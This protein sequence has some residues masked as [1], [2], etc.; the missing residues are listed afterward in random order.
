MRARPDGSGLRIFVGVWY[1][2]LGA[3]IT[4]LPPGPLSPPDP[5]VWLRGL[6][7]VA[8]GLAVFWL[9]PIDKRWLSLLGHLI[10]AG[11]QG[12]FAA[13]MINQGGALSPGLT[14]LV[15]AI[16]TGALPLYTLRS[17]GPI[18]GLPSYPLG[19]VAAAMCAVQGVATVTGSD[20][21]ALI[22]MAAGL[23]PQI[24]G[25][26][27]TLIG[28]LA[29][30]VCWTGFGGRRLVALT[31]FP[32]ALF[33]LGIAISA[34]LF[35]SSAYW[36]LNASGYV[37]AAALFLAPWAAAVTIDWRSAFA[38]TAVTVTSTAI[39]PLMLVMT[40]VLY[41]PGWADS[42]SLSDRQLLFGLIVLLIV[43]SVFGAL[44]AAR[45]LTGPLF[46][47]AQLL[48]KS[49]VEVLAHKADSPI[50]E[51]EILRRA[52]LDLYDKLLAQNAQ[53][54]RANSSK[55][56]F[57]GLVSHELKT[58]ITTIL[59]A[60][61]L[62]R[63]RMGAGEEGLV[64]DLEAETDR[65][66][67]IVDNLLA[68]ARM[69][70]GANSMTEPLMLSHLAKQE[71][72]RAGRRDT[73]REYRFRTEGEAVVDGVDE[74]IVM[75]L[76]N[77][78]TNA[79]KYSP[80]GGPIDV[81]VSTDGTDAVLSVHDTGVVLQTDEIAHVFEPFYR[82]E[83]AGKYTTGVGIGLAVC[84]RVAEA[85]GGGV[86]VIVDREPNIAPGTEFRLRLPL[87]ASD[88]EPVIEMQAQP[89]THESAAAP[90]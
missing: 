78:I 41:G 79:A 76:R 44:F 37:R 43:A 12:V 75:V 61:A 51:V 60:S 72:D 13:Q 26:A 81:R 57:L 83:S 33:V 1:V 35:V 58:P 30:A 6:A 66:A 42:I 88:V 69:D 89:A 46:G 49:S 40:L 2:V 47:L 86:E 20:R 52:V 16:A 64:D 50:T 7:T 18:H 53:L 55:D 8:G 67:S 22:L 63:Q 27:M 25:T 29:I 31:T 62:I 45:E 54:T 85:L 19:V 68:L 34:G 87:A 10:V 28:V 84:R 77:F 3:A 11:V 4:I 59:A 65:L 14:L 24:Y 39:A 23:S 15:V 21:S 82:A 56:E 17:A 48:R 71:V 36:V 74:Q 80:S 9:A 70:A 5:Y 38:R 32:S 73:T 90:A